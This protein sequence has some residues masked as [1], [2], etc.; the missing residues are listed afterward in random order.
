M[1]ACFDFKRRVTFALSSRRVFVDVSFNPANLVAGH[2]GL[3]KFEKGME[4]SCIDGS[5]C[6][7]TQ[8]QEGQ[9]SFYLKI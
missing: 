6:S 7:K 4:V 1:K 9:L 2:T 5:T 3:L 8:E